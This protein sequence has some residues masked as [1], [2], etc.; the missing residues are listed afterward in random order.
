M[1]LSINLSNYKYKL[2]SFFKI[3]VLLVG[4]GTENGQ[5]YW[6]VKNSW[7]TSWGENGF[8]RIVRGEDECAIESISVGADIVV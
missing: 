3:I 6:I 4:Y 1:I 5:D 7:G 8:F 2:I